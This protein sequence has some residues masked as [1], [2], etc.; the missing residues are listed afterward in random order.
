MMY[1]CKDC[2]DTKLGYSRRGLCGT[3]YVRDLKVRDPEYAARQRLRKKH[4][5]YGLTLEEW[6]EILSRGC[7]I[8][9]SKEN[10]R[11][12]HDHDTGEV[13]GCLCHRCNIGV[14]Y[15]EGWYREHSEAV[16]V[17]LSKA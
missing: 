10:P 17:Y 4:E 11:I 16:D 8:C 14:G 2:G 12:D 3:C 6:V 15:M 9:G 5:R 1:T 13:R 7:A